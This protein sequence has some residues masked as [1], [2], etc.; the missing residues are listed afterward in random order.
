VPALSVQTYSVRDDLG[1]RARETLR[2]L[3]ALGF[4]NVE[5]FDIVSDAEGLARDLEAAG[6]RARTAHADIVTL[7]RE[8]VVAAARRLGVETVI[9]PWADPDRFR[10]HAGIRELA[11]EIN[12]VARF[13]AHH[14]V[15]VGYHNHDFEFASRVRGTP[16]WE[17]L[18]DELDDEIVM[19]LD[20]YWASVG[21]ADVFELIPRRGSRLGYLHVNDEP[22]EP[23]DPPTLGV[24]VVGRM[25]EVVALAVP[26]VELIVVEIVVDG[27]VFPRLKR[28]T[29]SFQRM[30]AS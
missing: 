17:I 19:E 30:L 8:A 25:P 5:P 28:N 4:V 23:G 11:G 15:S 12:E 3:R 20:T 2:R 6:L 16:A 18:V 10:S 1:P 24:P 7:D 29:R 26:H 27:D 22:P 14:G 13:A 9:V 21:G